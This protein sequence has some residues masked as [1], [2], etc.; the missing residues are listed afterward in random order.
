MSRYA[1]LLAAALALLA[2]GAPAEP[3]RAHLAAV[4]VQQLKAAY[5]ECE[6][7]AS[8]MLLDAGDSTACSMLHE[9]LRQRGFGSDF[10]RMLAWWSDQKQMDAALAAPAT[11]PPSTAA[12]SG[13]RFASA[14]G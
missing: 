9:E 14:R 1:A 8:R 7:R 4:N 12:W 6:R 10:R 2:T 13:K 11:P 3:D 5:L